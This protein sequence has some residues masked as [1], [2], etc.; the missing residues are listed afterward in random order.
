M[1]I[2]VYIY[3]YKY[4]VRTPIFLKG[5]SK[6]WLPPWEVGKSEK[7]GLLKRRG[8]VD[9]HFSYLI[10]SRFIIFTFRNY[11]T[12]CKIVLCIWR[13]ITFFCHHNFMKN[14][15]LSCLKM[16]LNI[17]HKLRQP[18]CNGT[19]KNWFLVESDSWSGKIVLLIFVLTKKGWL[20]GLGQ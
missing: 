17:S 11:F 1:Y 15:I 2:Y 18:I 4:I 16:N 3:I 10:F 14:V 6:L 7:A 12:L 19:I 5:E 8:G 20:V 13:K 9:W